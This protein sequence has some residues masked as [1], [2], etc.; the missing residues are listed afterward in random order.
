M[1]D[2]QTNPESKALIVPENKFRITVEDFE[3]GETKAF[4]TACAS[5]VWVTGFDSENGGSCKGKNLISAPPVFWLTLMEALKEMS[6]NLE[7]E[8]QQRCISQAMEGE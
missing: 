3:T 8:F 4:E 6:V 1:K 2:N 5:I 7:K